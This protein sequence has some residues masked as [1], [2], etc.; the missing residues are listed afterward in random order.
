[1]ERQ[2]P[3]NRHLLF[4]CARWSILMGAWCGVHTT[5]TTRKKTEMCLRPQVESGVPRADHNEKTV[6][7][8]GRERYCLL[9]G[10]FYGCFSKTTTMYNL[11]TGLFINRYKLGV[12]V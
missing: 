4:E 7:S 9:T 12:S 1:M 2:K 10:A 8:C 6:T 3:C 11:V 5:D